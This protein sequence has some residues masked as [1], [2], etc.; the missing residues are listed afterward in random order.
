MAADV[1]VMTPRP[2]VRAL[3]LAAVFAIG[4]AA[5]IVA[6]TPGVWRTIFAILGGLVLLVAV[7]LGLLAFAMPRRQRVTV[8]LDDAGYRVDGPSGVRVG[9]WASVTRVT[10]V[11]GRLTLHQGDNERIHLVSPGGPTLQMDALGEAISR[12]L[13]ANR[14]YTRFEG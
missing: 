12:R 1:F 4:G 5:L 3:A 7:L 10:A 11:P 6:P 13:D 9:T 8:S 14:G 2:P